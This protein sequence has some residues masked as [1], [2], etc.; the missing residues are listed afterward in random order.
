[1]YPIFP[2]V[3]AWN[4]ANSA[5]AVKRAI[6]IGY[7]VCAGNIGG[8][9]G[10]YIYKEEEAPKY[11]TGFGSSLAFA[12]AGM[13]SALSIAFSLWKINARNAKI[14]EEEVRQKYTEDELE[15][16][17]EKSPLFKYSL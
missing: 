10:S 9:I 12:A 7:L 13:L 1:M 17:G 14:S 3:N 15:R 4:I 8:V 16:L 6:S 11:P 2:G 5:P